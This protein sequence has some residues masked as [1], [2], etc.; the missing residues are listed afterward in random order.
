M[1]IRDH[2]S[3]IA[4]FAAQASPVMVLQLRRPRWYTQVYCRG[5]RASWLRPVAVFTER[6]SLS[7]LFSL[8]KKVVLPRGANF[9]GRTAK[10][11]LI[12]KKMANAKAV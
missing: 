12:D 5:W 1:C 2:F 4:F 8:L 10:N 6:L 3:E 11:R 9:F 7:R